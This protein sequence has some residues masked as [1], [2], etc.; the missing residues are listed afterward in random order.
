M[1]QIRVVRARLLLSMAAVGVAVACLPEL[2]V[3]PPPPGDTCGSGFVD[4]AR[5]EACDP[6]DAGAV[7]CTAT[8]AIDC[9]GGAIDDASGHCY[10][11][12]ANLDNTLGAANACS[13]AG[14]HIVSVVGPEEM[15]FVL[16]QTG[17]LPNADLGA[18][19]LSLQ[20]ELAPNDAGAVTYASG[21]SAPGWAYT[22]PGCWAY[23][24]A[25]A[26][27][28]A[29]P[30]NNK[31][32]PCV[33]WRKSAYWIQAGCSLGATD[34]GLNTTSVLCEREP[35]GSFAAPC[36]ND[37]A[38]A[39]CVEVPAT[40]GKKRYVLGPPRSFAVARAECAARGGVLARFES[41]AE[42]EEVVA[43]V[44]PS[45]LVNDFW[46]GLAFDADAGAWTWDD[47]TPAPAAFPTPWADLEPRASAGAAS[48]HIDTS[49]FDTN[50]AHVQTD[51]TVTLQYLCQLPD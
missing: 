20:Q 42:R 34:A 19:W 2:I 26:Q 4:L 13:Q 7:G 14:G 24:E 18:S 16:A 10:F 49:T 30:G 51:T 47:G 25:G 21:L 40:F 48:I 45:L 36:A 50:L 3:A 32:A 44:A 12:V 37:D 15:D 35:P 39:T 8:C 27:D 29:R 9:D 38:G 5:G 17:A 6:G 23:V 22:C 11:W 46:I 33:N 43:A 1:V 31:P 41:G 28:I